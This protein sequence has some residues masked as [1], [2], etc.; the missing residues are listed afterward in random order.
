MRESCVAALAPGANACVGTFP[1]ESDVSTSVLVVLTS[2]VL[3]YLWS[4]GLATGTPTRDRQGRLR[5][6]SIARVRP[7]QAAVRGGSG[8]GVNS[9]CCASQ[10][11]S[12]GK[13]PESE[14]ER[15][16]GS[17]PTKGMPVL[18]VARQRGSSSRLGAVTRGTSLQRS[19]LT[20][21]YCCHSA[22]LPLAG[23]GLAGD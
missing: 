23:L 21:I 22:S 19:A 17:G 6:R 8:S 1:D 16:T 4:P 7:G 3:G 20:T 15:G 13:G 9:V 18:S 5:V 12:T 14:S 10:P 2:Q 11:A